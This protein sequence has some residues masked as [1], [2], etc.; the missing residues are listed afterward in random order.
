MPLRL[1]SLDACIIVAN[2][3]FDPLPQEYKTAIRNAAAHAI[4]P[5]EEMSR[6]QDDALLGGLFAKQGLTTIRPSADV[7]AEF[8]D[9]ARAVRE[10]MTSK[11]V[12]RELLD[13]VLTLLA[14][15]R[16]EH[17]DLEGR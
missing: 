7:R 9:A 6:A 12:P 5:L 2:R 17:R 14:D 4:E 8:F 15:Y 16:A 13:R 3:A 1:A 11:L 10:K